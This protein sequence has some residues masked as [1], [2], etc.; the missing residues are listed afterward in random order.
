M[1]KFFPA[2]DG[3]DNPKHK[4]TNIKLLKTEPNPPYIRN[5]SVPRCKQFPPRL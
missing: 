4:G 3:Q 1:S 5:Q 2:E